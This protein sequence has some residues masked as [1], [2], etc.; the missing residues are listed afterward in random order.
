M[1]VVWDTP[2][3]AGV[4]KGV[5]FF[6]SDVTK[7]DAQEIK[8]DQKGYLQSIL[9]QYKD[10]IASYKGQANSPCDDKIFRP[11]YNEVESVPVDPSA[12]AS[13]LMKV[14]YLVRTRPDIELVCS[15]LCT[16]SKNP[17]V[18]DDNYLNRFLKYLKNTQELGIHINPNNLQTV[19]YFDAGHAVHLDRKSQSGII[20]CLSEFGVPV[21]YRSVKQKLV[22]TSSTEAELI[23]MYEGLDFVLWFR[24][25]M[26]WMGCKQKTTIIFQDNTSTITIAYLGRGSSASK[27]K[28][29]NIK[30]FF[31]KSYIDNKTFE[32]QHLSRDNMIADFF[33]SPRTGQNFRKVR[34]M[35]MH[36]L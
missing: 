35:I 10:D 1:C 23:A 36:N 30:Y 4:E 7:T 27:T 16:R 33:A 26:E 12:F 28:H 3:P 34:D 14:R 11:V 22:A 18:G 31:V 8:I 19:A 9:D 25:I 13:K 6:P 24:Q 17:V 2:Y 29:I 20:V 5:T 21:H 32:I 15:A